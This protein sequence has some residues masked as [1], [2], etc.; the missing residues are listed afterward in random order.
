MTPRSELSAPEI[1]P[2]LD[3]NPKDR[4]VLRF[5]E[6]VALGEQLARAEL[7][8]V[9]LARLLTAIER[10]RDYET[11]GYASMGACMMEI[12]LLSGYSRSSAYAFV[13]LYSQCAANGVEVPTMPLT[14]AHLFKQ[15]PAQLQRDPKV[16]ESA[17]RKKPRDFRNEIA[18]NFPEAHIETLQ[19]VKLNL[20]A[21]LFSLWRE[22]IELVRTLDN[23]TASYEQVFET[24]LE[25]P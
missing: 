23:V 3:E 2:T 18:A 25:S 24:V 5:Q 14:T 4:A 11:L 12:E 6:A 20:D 19:E 15:L 10:D 13:K 9:M 16:R 21:S 17:E 8:W 22:A 1:R 7:A